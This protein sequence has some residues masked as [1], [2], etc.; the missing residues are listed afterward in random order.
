MI[1]PH[2][3]AAFVARDLGDEG[4]DRSAASSF[5]VTYERELVVRAARAL[6]AGIV[7]ARE[8]SPADGQ[9]VEAVDPVDRAVLGL[10][11]EPQA[12]HPRREEGERLLQLG[13]REV[14]AEA[15]VRAGA[16]GQRLARRG[17]R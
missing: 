10:A 13:A 8:R 3:A 2:F 1:G 12:R 9:R 6:M 16:E 7:P 14:R 15:V 5:F 17:R 11:V 4:A